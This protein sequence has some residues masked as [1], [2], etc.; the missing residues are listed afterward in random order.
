M[1]EAARFVVSLRGGARWCRAKGRQVARG[2]FALLPFLVGRKVPGFYCH[3]PRRKRRTVGFTEHHGDIRCR[4]PPS[5]K[6]LYRGPDVLGQRQDLY[7]YT[8]EVAIRGFVS[9]A[10]AFIGGQEKS[11]HHLNKSR[12][13]L[14]PG[15][16]K[17]RG[18]LVG[19]GPCCCALAFCL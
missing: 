7:I 6:A 16:N 5:I 2:E 18:E 9:V 10:V 1:I 17:G 4:R 3:C 12:R 14:W 13:G 11:V 15:Y 8:A 19:G